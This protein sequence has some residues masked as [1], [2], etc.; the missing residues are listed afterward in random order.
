MTSLPF[1]FGIYITFRKNRNT[2][3]TNIESM[4]IHYRKQSNK[5]LPKKERRTYSVHGVISRFKCVVV[6]NLGFFGVG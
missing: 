4:Q 5:G 3:C 2:I 1:T 6:N